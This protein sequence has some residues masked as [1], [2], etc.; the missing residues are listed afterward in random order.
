MMFQ[1]TIKST[2]A[3][4]LLTYLVQAPLA[5]AESSEQEALNN[6]FFQGMSARESGDYEASVKAFEGVLS[7][8]PTLNRARAELAVSYYKLLNF[9]AAKAQAQQILDNPETPEGVKINIRKFLEKIDNEGKKHIFTPYVT[10]GFGHDDNI[11]VGPSSNIINL[12]GAQLVAN[13]TEISRNYTL[14]NAG[15]AHR[16]LSPESVQLFNHSAAYLWQTNVSFF[17]NNYFNSS[18]FDL[19]VVSVN[20]GPLLVVAE[21]WR[22]GMDMTYDYIELG[23]SKLADFYGV[24]PKVTWN[25]SQFTDITLDAQ[26]QSRAFN[27]RQAPGR[28][29]TYHSLGLNI[30]RSFLDTKLNLQIGGRLFNENAEDNRRSNDGYQLLA[31]GNYRFNG[32]DSVYVK[33]IFRHNDFDGK[34]PLFNRS[35]D[36]DEN[37][38]SIGYNHKFTSGYVKDW[39]IDTSITH[40]H[41]NANLPIYE[42]RRTQYAVN[43]GRYF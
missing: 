37:R 10:F 35:R 21:K 28:D 3:V 30:A 40:T 4:S 22:L 39:S 8:D 42:Y 31:S 16:Y 38:T 24:T 15:L 1:Y 11:N 23:H 29:S 9:T 25:I 34:E 41:N 27:D 13:A 5:Y 12:G 17:Q 26:L 6:L 7:A 43:I 36:E 2:F 32:S 19:N 33:N 20:T 18:D 14:F